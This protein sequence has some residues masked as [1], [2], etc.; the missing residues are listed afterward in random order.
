MH[1][2]GSF[3]IW[4][5]IGLLLTPY[6]LLILGAGLYDYAYPSGPSTV[7]LA[8]LHMSIWWGALLLI[9]GVVYLVRFYPK[10]Q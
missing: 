3:S 8:D 6:G 4:F 5:F 1:G 2:H 7:V 9:I 10:K